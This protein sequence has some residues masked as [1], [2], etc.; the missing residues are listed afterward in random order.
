[1]SDKFDVIVVG[2]GPAGLASALVTA[3]AGLSTLVLERGDYSGSKNVFGGVIY[4]DSLKKLIPD[5]WKEA[6]VERPI[7]RRRITFM[8]DKSFL[9]FDYKNYNFRGDFY[10]GFSVFRSK[11]DEWF[12]KKVEEAGGMIAPGVKVDSL[13]HQDGKVSGVK[14]GND[15]LEADMVILADGAVSLLAQAEGLKERPDPNNFGLGMKEVFT[16]SEEEVNKRFG[17]TSKDG[18]EELI[19]GY[20]TKYLRGGGFIYTFKDSISIGVIVSLEA[21]RKSEYYA[22]DFMED[23]KEHPMI[24]DLIEGAQLKEYSAHAIPEGG[25]RMISKLY[26]DGVMVVGDAAGLVSSSGI[27]LNGVDIAVKSGILAAETAIEA[28]KVK[29]YSAKTLSLYEKKMEEKVLSEFR[30]FR[31][32][33]YFLENPRMYSEYPKIVTDLMEKII[34]SDG[35]PKQKLLNLLKC[36]INQWDLIKDAVKGVKSL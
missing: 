13:L 18:V 5:F 9:S 10:N 26:K 4:T 8:T 15:E 20:P 36:E 7:T 27:Y 23:L 34:I 12:S 2:G 35:E 19:L 29:D 11:F 32:A 24:Q 33:P 22:I 3:R 30:N 14:S 1:M 31:D 16:L 17:I 21:L 6:P 28:K 25:Y